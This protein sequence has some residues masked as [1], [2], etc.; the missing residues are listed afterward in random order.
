MGKTT[1]CFNE[2]EKT[3]YG[4]TEIIYFYSEYISSLTPSIYMLV[5]DNKMSLCPLYFFICCDFS[6]DG[7]IFHCEWYREGHPHAHHA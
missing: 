3:L 5:S 6:G 2:K 7:W 1:N 4:V